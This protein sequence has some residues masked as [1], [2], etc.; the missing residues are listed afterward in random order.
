MR[1]KLV[2]RFQRTTGTMHQP[3]T[4]G[5]TPST[6]GGSRWHCTKTWT[7]P[8]QR[9]GHSLSMFQYSVFF[10]GETNNRNPIQVHDLPNIKR[11]A[12]YM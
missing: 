8:V 1:E 12:R 5:K 11:V 6:R 3:Q 2:F 4:K 9:G 7:L 10:F